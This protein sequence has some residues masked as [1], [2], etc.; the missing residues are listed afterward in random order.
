MTDPVWRPGAPLSLVDV[1]GEELAPLSLTVEPGSLF[2]LLAPDGVGLA[3]VWRR[4][5]GGRRGPGQVLLDGAEVPPARARHAGLLG[6]AA[7]AH[8][9]ISFSRR[10]APEAGF[11]AALT[12]AR[13]ARPRAL[14]L[15]APLDA[16]PDAAP[17]LATLRQL[18]AAH[19]LTLLHLTRRRDIA[20]GTDRVALLDA[21]RLL[22][23][24]PP[25]TLY[26]RP[27][28]LRAAELTGAINCLPGTLLGCANDEARI[29]LDCGPVIEAY[30]P[31]DFLLPGSPCV[32][33]LRP[34]RIA[35]TPLATAE[36]G[37]QAVAAVLRDVIHQGETI[38]LIAA[39]G[40]DTSLTILRPSALGQRNL[41]P[42][43]A[44]SVAWQASQAMVFPAG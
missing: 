35:V 8:R 28:S 12:A 27:A 42:G 16:L 9:L 4:L 18:V 3:T 7:P 22:Q 20:F 10:A 39:I 1:A 38:R 5:V 25:A 24:G 23:L 21:G 31:S 6:V 26:E 36:L 19:R 43:R 44:V 37:G 13:R 15:N 17:H 40:T 34:E 11:A 29:R 41:A 32:V 14:V 33:V 2:C 30:A